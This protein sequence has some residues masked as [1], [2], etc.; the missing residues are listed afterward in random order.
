MNKIIRFASSLAL[1]AASALSAQQPA[2]S[3]HDDPVY[4]RLSPQ[5]RSLIDQTIK[6]LDNAICH[7]EVSIAAQARFEELPSFQPRPTPQKR[8]WF[9]RLLT[10]TP[11]MTCP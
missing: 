6:D 7:A 2:V 9:G 11:R 5:Q 8:G 3:L 1:S 10:L 4:T